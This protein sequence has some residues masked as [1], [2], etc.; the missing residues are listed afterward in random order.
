[1]YHHFIPTLAHL[2]FFNKYSYYL[3][4]HPSWLSNTSTG[5]RWIPR[6]ARLLIPWAR[7]DEPYDAI[8]LAEIESLTF[9]GK[10]DFR[11]YYGAVKSTN[12]TPIQDGG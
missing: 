2:I 11:N 7:K 12:N 10:Y 5:Q 1:M 8:T 4:K 3:E 9:I 6:F